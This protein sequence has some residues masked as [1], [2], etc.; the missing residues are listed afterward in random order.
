M[1]D[2]KNESNREL[3]ADSQQEINL[4][5]DEFS[6][7]EDTE[8]KK[9][10][11]EEVI[12]GE[13]TSLPVGSNTIPPSTEKPKRNRY[14]IAFFTLGSVIILGTALFFGYQYMK[15]REVPVTENLCLDTDTKIY[16]A[17]HRN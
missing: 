12:T 17:G 4:P 2:E 15:N 9:L 11:T 5:A 7:K 1:N 16:D 3:D 14:K 10:G 13:I 8:S 6:V